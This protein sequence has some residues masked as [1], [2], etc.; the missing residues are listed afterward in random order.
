M[1]AS[2]LCRCDD[3]TLTGHRMNAS[4]V[5]LVLFISATY[6]LNRPCVYCSILLAILVLSLFDFK[7][8]W[9]EP[10]TLSW[11]GSNSLDPSET[12]LANVSL[13]ANGTE[14]TATALRDRILETVALAASAVDSTA[15]AVA[16]AAGETWR[17]MGSQGDGAS[18]EL[19]RSMLDRKEWRVPCFG[20]NVRL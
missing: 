18:G 17:K 9:F 15:T 14:G 6:V 1:I 4:P 8:N 7:S 19:A 16:E 13:V 11:L 10:R 20:V 3:E 2:I 12:Q 5:Y